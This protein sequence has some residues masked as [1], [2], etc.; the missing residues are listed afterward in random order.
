MMVIMGFGVVVFVCMVVD[1][2]FMCESSFEVFLS[3][4]SV[5]VF[6]C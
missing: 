6:V 1:G 2:L 3:E 5:D 4:M